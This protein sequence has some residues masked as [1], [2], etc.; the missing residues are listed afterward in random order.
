MSR[1]CCLGTFGA[2]GNSVFGTVIN[3][4]F[5]HNMLIEVHGMVGAKVGD[6]VYEFG[7]LQ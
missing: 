6:L 4:V 7:G 2:S 5:G 3:F 1:L